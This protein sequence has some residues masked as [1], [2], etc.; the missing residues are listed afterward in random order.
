MKLPRRSADSNPNFLVYR[1]LPSMEP[2]VVIIGFIT[3]IVLIRLAVAS[4]DGDRVENYV[5]GMGCELIEKSW[6]P[7]GPGWF[8]SQNSRIYEIVYKDR[9]GRIHRAHVKTSMLGGVYLT[10][11]RIIEESGTLTVE[12][13][14]A[15]LRKRLA[16]LERRGERLGNDTAKRDSA[17]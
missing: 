5:R 12:E 8:G 16:E 6:D 10:N 13:E 11:D 9:D 17:T 2:G 4:F 7:F 3:L 15:A 14:K 1:N